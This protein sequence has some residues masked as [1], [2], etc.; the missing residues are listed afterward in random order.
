MLTDLGISLTFGTSS[1]VTG[2]QLEVKAASLLAFS[3]DF[4][5]TRPASLETDELLYFF[6]FPFLAKPP[7]LWVSVPR[8]K[9]ELRP[10]L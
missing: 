7:D 3:C 4:V 6:S 1:T 2:A 9:T 5:G 8:P 10:Q